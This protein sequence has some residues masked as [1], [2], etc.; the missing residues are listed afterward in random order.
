MSQ[1]SP[2][3]PTPTTPSP[4]LRLPIARPRWVWVFL[5]VNIVVWLLMTASGGSEN[6][7]V[8]I[9]FGANAPSRIV[10]YGEVWRL[11][12]ANFLHIG[13]V[14]LFF[15]S[16]ALYALG[17]EMEA[18]YGSERFVAI[19]VL[20]GLSGSIASFA[21]HTDLGLSAGA[22]TALFGIVGTMIAFFVRNRQHFGA[23][24]T[25]RLYSYAAMAMLN[26]FIGLSVPG[27][28][29]LGHVGGFVG[30]LI[31]GWLLCPF[32]RIEVREGQPRVV[33]LNSLRSE[34]LGVTLFAV[35]LAV[36]VIGGITRL[37]NVPR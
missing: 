21:L 10:L 36:S 14:H 9:A 12:T 30:G 13:L 17:P 8:L 20:S 5:S 37:G 19:Y 29:T 3:T 11:F 18:L 15:N 35:L 22:S 32:Y 25:Q 26:L 34:W 16:Y 7:S 6:R 27:I 28:D 4:S 2:S 1:P 23:R 31:L 33:D 24:G